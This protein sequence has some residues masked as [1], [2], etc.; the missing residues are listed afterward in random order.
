MLVL[1]VEL[2]S[3]EEGE[4]FILCVFHGVREERRGEKRRGEE[5]IRGGK[6]NHMSCI[7]GI[8]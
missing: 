3:P 6:R 8:Y 4:G 2:V 5:K 1:S 7:Q